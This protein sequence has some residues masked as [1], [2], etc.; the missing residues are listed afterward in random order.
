LIVLR[1]ESRSPHPDPGDKEDTMLVRRNIRAQVGVATIAAALCVLAV[2]GCATKGY[3]RD[4]VGRIEEADATM[5]RDLHRI[6]GEASDANSR[7]ESALR[8]AGLARELA[9]GDV[10]FREVDRYTIPFDFD[11]AKLT[12]EARATLDD[13][14]A[15]LEQG[16]RYL[17]DIYG[18]TD[19]I[20]SDDYNDVLSARRANEVLRYLTNATD[21]PLARF[22]T[23][24]L[25]EREPIVRGSDEDHEG[26]RRVVVRLLE[27]TAPVQATQISQTPKP[28]EL[29]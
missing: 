3:V 23:L 2:S 9:L 15:D 1:G 5:Q 8:D 16:R 13:A 7:A 22:A 20:G 12:T 29:P 27:R 21:A 14:A 4:E 18:Y 6:G 17:V 28:G 10:S 19:T 25:G 11:S 26:G 24:G